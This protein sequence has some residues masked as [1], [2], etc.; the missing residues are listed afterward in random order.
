MIIRIFLPESFYRPK[1]FIDSK[2]YFIFGNIIK[3]ENAENV[4]IYIIDIQE[5]SERTTSNRQLIGKISKCASDNTKL[6]SDYITF[7]I[8]EN[9]S[10]LK[11]QAIELPSFI[12]DAG[13]SRRI[14]IFLYDS[15]SF[16]ELS[17]RNDEVSIS[18]KTD[19]ISKLLFLIRNCDDDGP[20]NTQSV[21]RKSNLFHNRV[22]P[23]LTSVSTFTQNKLSFLN[24]AFL[25]HFHFWVC[26][27]QKM[28]HNK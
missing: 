9:E 6:P 22:V 26:N 12:P 1:L 15:K 14:Q 4:S 16:A 21:C 11:L 10:K 27:L 17:Q 13:T 3:D 20:A 7:G 5:S 28:T 2:L 8:D 19:P 23:I 18:L 24:S 25:N